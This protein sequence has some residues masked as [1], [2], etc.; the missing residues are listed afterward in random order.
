MLKTSLIIERLDFIWLPQNGTN[1]ISNFEGQQHSDFV[2]PFN[3]SNS[4]PTVG[5]QQTVNIV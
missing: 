2:E 3:V 4:G 5:S 1:Y